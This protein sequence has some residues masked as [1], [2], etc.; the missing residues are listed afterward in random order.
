MKYLGVLLDRKLTYKDHIH[1]TRKKAL[2]AYN[3]LYPYLGRFSVLTVQLYKAYIKPF[4]TY[5]R[6]VWINASGTK[7]LQLK[8]AELNVLRTILDMRWRTTPIKEIY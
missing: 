8:T 3:V 7:L 5:A 1:T 4:L 6:P 2:G